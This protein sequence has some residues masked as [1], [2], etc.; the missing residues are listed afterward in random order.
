MLVCETIDFGPTLAERV[1]R[2]VA[3]RPGANVVKDGKLVLEAG[4]LITVVGGKKVVCACTQ[5]VDG[6]KVKYGTIVVYGQTLAEKPGD[7][8]FPD[9]VKYVHMAD[10]TTAVK[11]QMVEVFVTKP[12]GRPV[13]AGGAV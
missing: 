7:G 5:T 6:K 1:S 13:A 12:F 11:G 8:D 10:K 9:N 3:T 4:K 2:S